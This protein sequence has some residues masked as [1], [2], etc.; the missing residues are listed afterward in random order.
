MLAKLAPVNDFVSIFASK[1]AMSQQ[2]KIPNQYLVYDF[3]YEGQRH[4]GKVKLDEDTPNL[5]MMY[6]DHDIEITWV[7]R[8]RHKGK[9]IELSIVVN[10]D[11]YDANEGKVIASAWICVYEK[12]NLITSFEPDCWSYI[13]EINELNNTC[14]GT[15]YV[16]KL[17][18][19][20]CKLCDYP[21][22]CKTR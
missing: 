12:D 18:T 7:K 20:G 3:T 19:L 14:K 4:K 6:N 15:F 1:K 8:I 9:Y 21:K 11:A 13:D 17:K 2:E 22:K 5:Y 10:D 16:K